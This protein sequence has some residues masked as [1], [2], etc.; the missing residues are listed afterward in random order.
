MGSGTQDK[1]L[2]QADSGI[3][4]PGK[5]LDNGKPP[6]VQG[7]VQYFPR[8]LLAVADISK[9]GAQKYALD[10]SD[11]NWFRVEGG[12]ARYSDALGRHLFGEFIDGRIDPESGK[13][14]AAMVAWNALARLELILAKENDIK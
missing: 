14:H 5:K 12:F 6:I 9:Y 4:A 1:V 3:L 10:Y 11:I 13:L 7:V 8:S 2:H